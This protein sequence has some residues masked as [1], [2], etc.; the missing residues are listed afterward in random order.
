MAVGATR[1]DGETTLPYLELVSKTARCDWRPISGISSGGGGGGMKVQD[2]AASLPAQATPS[3]VPD[4]SPKGGATSTASHAH[5]SDSRR[6]DEGRLSSAIASVAALDSTAPTGIMIGCP[7]EA[8]DNC[9]TFA[10]IALIRA[11]CAA[12][13]VVASDS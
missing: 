10:L 7:P 8:A 4:A 1:V 6:F 13:F 12:S 2:T 5:D 11:S 3:I 9:A